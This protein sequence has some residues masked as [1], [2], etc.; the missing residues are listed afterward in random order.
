MIKIDKL[1]FGYGKKML[2]QDLS[3]QMSF[4]SKNRLLAIVGPNGC[5][6][7]TLLK[8][9]AGHLKWQSG[10]IWIDG[11]L[12]ESIPSKERPKVL[13]MIQQNL[14]FDF[15]FSCFDTVLMGRYAHKSEFEDYRPLD[16]EVSLKALRE[17]EM[18]EFADKKVTEVSGG[19]FQRILIARTMAQGP[20]IVLLD[21]AF[22]AMDIKH[23]KKSIEMLKRYAE[24]ND[25]YIIMVVH[26]INIAYKYADLVMMMR[27]G[28]IVHQGHT[29]ETI[30]EET[31]YSIFD[32]HMKKMEGEGFL[33]I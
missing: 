21:E 30:N 15:P 20:K 17:V 16:I 14:K 27:K 32:V 13:G 23:K 10:H 12:S 3:C 19:E 2:F 25:A 18:E 4:D 29:K 26:D 28:R 7:S 33:L 5:G 22:S 8:M 11:R 9:I 6:K 31:I 24:T 1:S